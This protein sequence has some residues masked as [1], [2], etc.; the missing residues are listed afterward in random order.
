[1]NETEASEVRK[2]IEIRKMI[3]IIRALEMSTPF[4]VNG[5]PKQGMS[6][7]AIELRRKQ[8]ED[9]RE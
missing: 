1:M 9:T 2:L 8:Q 6:T 5:D 3:E 4:Y 7:L